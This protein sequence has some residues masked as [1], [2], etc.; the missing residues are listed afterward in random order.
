VCE[1]NNYSKAEELIRAGANRNIAAETSPL[2]EACRFANAAMVALLLNRGIGTGAKKSKPASPNLAVGNERPLTFI[3]TSLKAEDHANSA[4]YKIFQRLLKSGAKPNKGIHRQGSTKDNPLKET[5]L[6]L[7]VRRNLPF[8]VRDLLAHGANP[9]KKPK[10]SQRP[11]KIATELRYTEIVTLLTPPQSVPAA[12][13]A[14]SKEPHAP[15]VRTDSTPIGRSSSVKNFGKFVRDVRDSLPGTKKEKKK[16]KVKILDL[17][18]EPTSRAA[19]KAGP[20][21]VRSPGSSAQAIKSPNSGT[22]P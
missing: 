1:I 2:L 20:K 9:D 21:T 16:K 10:G 12:A 11:I 7:A 8:A 13:S 17:P 14:V 18:P 5:P 15:L 22:S 6:T 19:P 3:I 4:E